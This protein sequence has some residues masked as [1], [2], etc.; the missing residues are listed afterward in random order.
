MTT[1]LTEWGAEFTP[2]NVVWASELDE[3]YLVEVQRL[4]PDT[5]L[6]VAFDH[7]NDDQVIHEEEV[8]LAYGAV[9]G[10]DIEDVTAWQDRI[11]AI[12]DGTA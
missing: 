6:L 2:P 9:F 10:P 12:V 1:P 7:N 11:E 8:S 4:G 5:G 3:R